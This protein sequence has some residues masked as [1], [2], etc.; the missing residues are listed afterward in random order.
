MGQR[1]II[2]ELVTVINFGVKDGNSH[3]VDGF[4]IEVRTNTTKLTN[5]RIAIFR[6]R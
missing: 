5:M 6:Q 1:Q 4:K 3:D 2:V